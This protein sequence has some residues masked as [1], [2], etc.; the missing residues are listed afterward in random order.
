MRVTVTQECMLGGIVPKQNNKAMYTLLTLPGF[1]KVVVFGDMV[2]GLKERQTVKA[3]FDIT[4]KSQRLFD[5]KGDAQFVDVAKV[6]L[7][8]IEV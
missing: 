7:K 1:D 6:F 2:Q 8:G 3:T 5:N 4:I